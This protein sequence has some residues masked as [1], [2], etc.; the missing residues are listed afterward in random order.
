MRMTKHSPSRYFKT[1]SEIGRL[2]VMLF[3][4]FP[5]SLRNLED[6][7]HERGIEISHE[8]VRFWWNRFGTLFAAEIRRQR[9]GRVRSFSNWKWHLNEVFVKIDGETLDL[10][11]AVAFNGEVLESYVIKRRNRR[12]SLNFLRKIMNRHG[13]VEVLVTDQLRSYGA[14]MKEI[15]NTNRQKP[16]VDSTTGVRIHSSHFEGENGRFCAFGACEV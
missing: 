9:T 14:A 6:P 16:A 13:K 1:S 2:A 12:S 11:R 10:W 5:L 3:V 15:G 7:L 8:T 4:Q